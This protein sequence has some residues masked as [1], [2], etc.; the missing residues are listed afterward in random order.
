[1]LYA[2]HL[3][4]VSELC[5]AVCWLPWLPLMTTTINSR[6]KC[7]RQDPET[8]SSMLLSCV[9]TIGPTIE[10]HRWVCG[11]LNI[12]ACVR[13][14]SSFLCPHTCMYAVCSHACIR[15][16]ASHENCSPPFPPL[17]PFTEIGWQITGRNCTLFTTRG[18]LLFVMQSVPAGACSTLDEMEDLK[19]VWGHDNSKDKHLNPPFFCLQSFAWWY[20]HT[21]FHVLWS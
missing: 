19:G 7:R 4:C 5:Y 14:F 10:M 12:C 21:W 20:I 13:E 16:F 3:F 11:R 15:T 1:M 18:E 8:V 2:L 9:I 6:R 17:L